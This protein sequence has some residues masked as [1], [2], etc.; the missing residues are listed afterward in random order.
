L[1]PLQ[2]LEAVDLIPLQVMDAISAA[3]EPTDDDGA[4]P[5]VDVIPAQISGL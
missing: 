4:F 1:L 3:L 2:E 5:Q